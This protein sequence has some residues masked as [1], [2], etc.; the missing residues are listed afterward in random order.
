MDTPPR[1]APHVVV[2]GGPNGA[3]QSTVAPRLLRDA[4]GITAFINADDL[5]R[6]LSGFAPE[7]AALRAGR[8]MLDRLAELTRGHATFAFE[9][10]LAGLGM[11][12]VLARCLDAGY[13]VHLVYL[14][15]PSPALALARV[16]RRVAAGGHAIPERDVRRRWAR[17]LVNFFDH[18]VPLATTWRVYDGSAPTRAP[19]VARA[20]A[21]QPPVVRNAA[22]WATINAQAETIRRGAPLP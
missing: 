13:R 11:R 7:A 1:A 22:V 21:G 5:A 15:L 17:S 8:L 20:A 10:T 6:G 16:R 18:C 2:L 9:S 19:A 12:A 14:W 3:G 4:L